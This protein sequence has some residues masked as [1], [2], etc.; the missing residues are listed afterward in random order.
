M[1]PAE[2][3]AALEEKVRE[4]QAQVALM[5]GARVTHWLWRAILAAR[6]AGD[7]RLARD[8]EESFM[9]RANLLDER[10]TP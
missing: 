1:K 6:E 10:K 5:S 2:R 9:V 3:V 7:N 4:L 8:I